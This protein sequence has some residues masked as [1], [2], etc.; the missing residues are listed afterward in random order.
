VV[1]VAPRIL[2]PNS[3]R[4]SWLLEA[5]DPPQ[6]LHYEL[7]LELKLPIVRHVLPLAAT[8]FAKVFARRL[9]SPARGLQNLDDPPEQRVRTLDIDLGHNALA[10][11]AVIH[12]YLAAFVLGGSGAV[13]RK[14][15]KRQL[16]TDRRLESL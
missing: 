10:R 16:S 6:L 12:K 8:A 11:N 13:Q 5:A 14:R 7:S 4:D 1:S 2:R 9:D 3:R 15:T